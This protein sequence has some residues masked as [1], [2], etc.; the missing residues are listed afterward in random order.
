MFR[1][2]DTSRDITPTTID[3]NINFYSRKHF[4]KEMFEIHRCIFMKCTCCLFTW[5]ILRHYPLA[6]LK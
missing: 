2:S 1:E 6:P 5:K 4:F 3:S